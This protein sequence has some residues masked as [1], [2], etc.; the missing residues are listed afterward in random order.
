MPD[1]FKMHDSPAVS[2]FTVTPSDTTVFD[3]PTRGLWVGVTGNIAVR[4]ADG[5]SVTLSNVPVG[6]Y[7]FALDMVKSTSTTATTMIGLR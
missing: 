4:F 5:T 7:P 3:P 1:V 6:L 2:G